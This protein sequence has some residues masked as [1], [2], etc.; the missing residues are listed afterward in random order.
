MLPCHLRNVNDTGKK[1]GGSFARISLPGEPKFN[2]T[3]LHM[4]T[5]TRRN[6][7]HIL[8]IIK[9][10]PFTRHLGLCANETTSNFS[11]K[12]DSKRKLTT[13]RHIASVDVW[14]FGYFRKLS[15][16]TDNFRDS[17]FIGHYY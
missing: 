5:D 13:F 10:V 4:L 11:K 1:H 17:I 6:H 15:I 7:T 16:S 9:R 2:E 8:H 12:S 14:L 3:R